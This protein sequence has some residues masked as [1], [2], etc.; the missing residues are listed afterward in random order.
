MLPQKSQLRVLRKELLGDIYK[1]KW[2]RNNQGSNQAEGWT[3]QGLE[4]YMENLTIIEAGRKT[5]AGKIWEK[6]TLELI[7]KDASHQKQKKTKRQEVTIPDE[8]KEEL[9]VIGNRAGKYMKECLERAM[10]KQRMDDNRINDVDV[11]SIESSEG[12]EDDEV[13]DDE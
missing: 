12:E 3:R 11:E 7:Q 9:D 8:P 10:K 2:S 4:R 13:N 5:T 6:W 1:G